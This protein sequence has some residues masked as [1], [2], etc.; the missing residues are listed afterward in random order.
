LEKMTF[1]SPLALED[2]EVTLCF[3]DRGLMVWG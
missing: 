3:R 1:E 2:L